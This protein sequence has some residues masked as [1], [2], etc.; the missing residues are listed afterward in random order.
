MTGDAV[1]T[2]DFYSTDNAGNVE[3]TQS[4]TFKVDTTPPTIDLVAPVEAVTQVVGQPGNYPLN[5]VQNASYSCADNFSGVA[6]CVGTVP[7]GSPF[8]TSTVGFHSFTVDAADVAGNTATVT[9]QYNVVWDGYGGF[10]PP[11]AEGAVNKARAGSTIPLKFRL[12]ADYGL[13]VLQAGYPQSVQVDCASYA[14]IGTPEPTT[15]AAGLV[16]SDDQY[17]YEWKTDRAWSGTCRQLIIELLDNTTHTA[18][19]DFR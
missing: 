18:I 7:D 4:I 6:S 16:W 2:L 1:H 13:A 9:H 15:S 8:D 12:G 14:P 17:Q 5:S 19:I 11:L 10:T 3:S